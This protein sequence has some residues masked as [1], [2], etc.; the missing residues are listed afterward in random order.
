MKMARGCIF[1]LFCHHSKK[2]ECSFIFFY[3]NTFNF[4]TKLRLELIRRNLILQYIHFLSGH[5]MNQYSIILFYLKVKEWKV[6]GNQ[7]KNV[8]CKN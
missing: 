3:S 6:Y 2:E 1:L 8:G 4:V 5:G 7:N